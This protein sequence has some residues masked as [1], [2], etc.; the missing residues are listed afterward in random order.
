MNASPSFER[1]NY[2][3]RTNKNIERKL[4]FDLLTR[5]YSREVCSQLWYLGFG[6]MWFSDF[7]LAHRHLEIEEMISIERLDYADR[8][9]FNSPLASIRVEPG[10]SN[11]V[12]PKLVTERAEKPVIAWLDFDGYL[13]ESVVTDINTLLGNAAANSVLIFSV[14]SHLSNYKSRTEDSKKRAKTETAAGWIES[15]LGASSIEL[16]YQPTQLPNESYRDSVTIEQ[17]PE[18]LSGALL[19]Y[20]KHHMVKLARQHNNETI[21]FLPLF[22]LHHQD[23][24]PMITVGGAVVTPSSE[25]LWKQA[26][27][28]NIL[29]S[30][31]TETP[32]Y[33]RLDLIPLTIK[34]KITLDSCLP[35]SQGEE[36]YLTKVKAHGVK[37]NEDELKKYLLFYKH[38]PIF[39]ETPI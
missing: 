23:G 16:K 2:L 15:I 25:K 33:R 6:S 39:M 12:L 37:L 1:L 35:D 10:E 11:A 19:T 5:A 38:F 34:E 24:A 29:L 7:K 3:L 30:N 4:I 32:C 18:F 28:E 22:Q 31:N 14:N 9:N 26:L 8:A 27:A 20:M 36:N 21:S 17:F 13:D